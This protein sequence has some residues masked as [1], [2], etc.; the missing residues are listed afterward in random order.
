MHN[1]DEKIRDYFGDPVDDP[2]NPFD[3][4]IYEAYRTGKMDDETHKVVDDMI[5]HKADIIKDYDALNYIYQALPHYTNCENETDYEL[6]TAD[7]DEMM[8]MPDDGAQLSFQRYFQR[9]FGD[10]VVVEKRELG[11]LV[12]VYRSRSKRKPATFGRIVPGVVSGDEEKTKMEDKVD[13]D[14][15]LMKNLTID[16]L[17]TK[18]RIGLAQGIVDGYLNGKLDRYTQSVLECIEQHSVSADDYAELCD[19]YYHLGNQ[20]R[21]VDETGIIGS[22]NVDAIEKF[23]YQMAVQNYLRS[24]CGPYLVVEQHEFNK[25]VVRPMSDKEY[26]DETGDF[27]EKANSD[28]TRVPNSDDLAEFWSQ[29]K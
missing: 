4:G 5:G 23:P 25:F 17:T 9:R 7:M 12:L 16:D 20:L 27:R 1:L 10:D 6:T 29:I 8:S 3:E 2:F 22:V 28:D 13:L 19:L 18:Q 24:E 14:N 26:E 15:W 11:Q 21:I